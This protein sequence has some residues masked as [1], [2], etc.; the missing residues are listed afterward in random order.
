MESEYGFKYAS[1][2]YLLIVLPR[3][4]YLTSVGLTSIICKIIVLD[5]NFTEL[6]Q[7]YRHKPLPNSGYPVND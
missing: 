3:A 4:S 1:L 6:A 5:T 2:L 7:G